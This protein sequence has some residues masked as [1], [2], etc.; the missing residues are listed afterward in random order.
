M[1]RINNRVVAGRS[2][3]LCA[4]IIDNVPSPEEVQE[5]HIHIS[6]GIGPT[7]QYSV[8]VNGITTH[9]WQYHENNT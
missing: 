9:Q 1:S 2:D 6:L 3:A 8:I 4:L 5:V 7:S